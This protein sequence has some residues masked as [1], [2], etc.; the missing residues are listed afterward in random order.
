LPLTAAA[1]F[2]LTRPLSRSRRGGRVVECACLESTYRRKPI[3]GSNPPLSATLRSTG[4][5]GGTATVRTSGISAGRTNTHAEGAP[6]SLGV[7]GHEAS[8]G[9]DALQICRLN[10]GPLGFRAIKRALAACWDV[11][12]VSS[13]KRRSSQTPLHRIHRGPTLPPAATQRGASAQYSPWTLATYL[14]FS[15]KRQALAFESY[16]KTGFGYA[17]SKNRLWPA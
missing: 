11:L 13:K 16:L 6:R 2:P 8:K 7:V 3:G 10:S 14:A 4:A 12:R 15:S 17:F 9:R 1:G 5:S